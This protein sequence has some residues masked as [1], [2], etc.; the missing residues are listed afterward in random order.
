MRKYVRPADPKATI[1]DP[2]HGRDLPP[3][4]IAVEWSAYWARLLLRGDVIV[5]EAGGTPAVPE[6]TE[7]A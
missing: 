3:G 1:L 2:A 4:G 5:E 6:S 7:E